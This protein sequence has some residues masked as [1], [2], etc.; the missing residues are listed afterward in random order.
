[1]DI[2]LSCHHKTGTYFLIALKKLIQQY[3]KNNYIL[4]EWS[5]KANK[6][7]DSIQINDNNLIDNNKNKPIKI[8][9]MIRHPY[10]IIVS[11]YF[12]HKICNEKWC[13]DK[14]SS[15]PS[16]NINYN[17]DG[18]S[19]QEKLNTL[20][21]EDGLNFEME[22]LGNSTINDMYNSNFTDYDFCLNIKMED[23]YTAFDNTIKKILDFIDPTYFETIDYS[24]LSLKNNKRNSDHST[25]KLLETER[26]KQYFTTNNY[27]NFN[28]IFAQVN[29]DKYDYIIKSIL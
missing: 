1:M 20:S 2:Y 17:F 27:Q 18:L 14:N 28:K 3:D 7:N 19:Y 11:G 6:I 15:S 4:D 21:L 22:K 24:I 26:H 16:D 13:I 29:F 10:E 25:N 5:H 9:H 23:L 12:Y 8:I